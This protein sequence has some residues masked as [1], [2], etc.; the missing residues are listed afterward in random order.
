ML[1]AFHLGGWGMYPT[2]V[3]G[4]ILMYSAFQF[5]RHPDPARLRVVRCLGVLVVLT[6]TLGFVTGVINTCTHVTPDLGPDLGMTVVIGVGESLVN[7]GAGLVWLV[8]AT[9]TATVGA[10]RARSTGADLADPHGP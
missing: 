6:S 4:L 9:I 3:A 2:L 7:I 10:S 8:L 5:A 1:D